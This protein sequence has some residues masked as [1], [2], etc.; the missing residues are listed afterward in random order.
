MFDVSINSILLS[1]TIDHL[2][3]GYHWYDIKLYFLAFGKKALTNDFLVL[4]FKSILEP[5][6]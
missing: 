1:L 3:T 5:L 2:E 4:S 6:W